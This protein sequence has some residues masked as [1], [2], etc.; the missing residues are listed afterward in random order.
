[1]IRRVFLSTLAAFFAATVGLAPLTIGA[2]AGLP[3]PEQFVGFPLAPTTSWRAG[4]RSSS[5]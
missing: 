5:T 3:T 1:M 4:T 2:T